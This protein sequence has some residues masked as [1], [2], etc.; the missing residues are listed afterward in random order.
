MTEA[1]GAETTPS[2]K[3][4]GKGAVEKGGAVKGEKGE[5]E[6]KTEGKKEEKKKKEPKKE[7]KLPVKIVDNPV[8][9]HGAGYVRW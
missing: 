4:E 7:E 8:T 2:S 6:K 5:E 1:K 9:P 3:K